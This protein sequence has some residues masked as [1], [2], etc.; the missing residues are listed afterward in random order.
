MKVERLTESKE[1]VLEQHLTE[2]VD[3]VR[4]WVRQELEDILD[5]AFDNVANHM[6]E[7]FDDYNS[8][9]CQVEAYGPNHE[10]LM[11]TRLAFLN[12]VEAMLF[13]NAPRNEA[14]T[15]AVDM[16]TMKY[17]V[18][19]PNGEYAGVPCESVDEACRF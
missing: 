10:R 9:W 2:D 14:L 5:H 13:A 16:S 18:I 1:V 6:V 12:A 4:E 7:F 8:E 17:A 15:E 19:K 11:K 3:Q